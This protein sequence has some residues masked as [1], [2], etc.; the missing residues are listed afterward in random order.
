MNKVIKA[1][2]SVKRKRTIQDMQRSYFLQFIW[3]YLCDMPN[4]KLK[5]SMSIKREADK[6][7]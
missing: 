2:V 1:L 4:D 6:D 5:D 7:K 3:N